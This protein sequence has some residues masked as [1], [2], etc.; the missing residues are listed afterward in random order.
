MQ[1][2]KD[3][4]DYFE[5]VTDDNKNYKL[6]IETAYGCHGSCAGCPLSIESRNSQEPKWELN[7]LDTSL[8]N[9][10]LSISLASIGS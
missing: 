5:K 4:R 10:F 7:K 1:N 3:W 6:F 9:D 8:K 2:S